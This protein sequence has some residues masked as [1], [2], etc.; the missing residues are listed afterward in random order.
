MHSAPCRP[1]GPACRALPPTTEQD[2]Y[3][4][5]T[6]TCQS[7]FGGLLV[8][9][10]AERARRRTTVASRPAPLRP[11]GSGVRDRREFEFLVRRAWRSPPRSR[12]RVRTRREPSGERYAM[13]AATSRARPQTPEPLR[14]T[15]SSSHLELTLSRGPGRL[16]WRP[17]WS[18]RCGRRS[19]ACSGTRPRTGCTAS[20]RRDPSSPRRTVANR[21]V[22]AVFAVSKSVTGVAV[23]NSVH[24]L[25]TRLNWTGNARIAPRPER[26]PLRASHRVRRAACTAGSL[27]V[28]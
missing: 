14:N 21:F 13:Y 10:G 18:G 6:G 1:C 12:C 2:E 8:P 28:P 16:R 7:S 19:S 23:K 27:S 15:V 22:S 9:V 11:T 4:P 25:P 20:R 26:D 3:P 5:P 24:M 17:R